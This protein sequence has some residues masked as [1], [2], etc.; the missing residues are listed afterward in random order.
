MLGFTAFAAK[1][2]LTGDDIPPGVLQLLVLTF[3][4]GLG[5]EPAADLL[6]QALG[7]KKEGDTEK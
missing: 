4:A 3:G 5:A 7:K 1:A 2:L 6:K